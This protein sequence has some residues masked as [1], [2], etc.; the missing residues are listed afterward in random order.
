MVFASRSNRCLRTG[1]A[2][3]CAGRILMAT[4]R[5]NRVSLARYTSPIPPAPSGTPI[6]YGPSLVPGA[7]GMSGAIITPEKLSGSSARSEG[8]GV[9]PYQ[10][11][12]RRFSYQPFYGAAWKYTAVA[13]KHGVGGNMRSWR[14]CLMVLALTYAPSGSAQEAT[15]DAQ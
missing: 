7:M 13:R 3:N 4:V 2:E 5:S 1:S 8:E 9:R 11:R 12:S 14:G 15:L 10:T 6:S